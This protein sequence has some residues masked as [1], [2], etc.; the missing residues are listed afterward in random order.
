MRI[1]FQVVLSSL[2]RGR[3]LLHININTIAWLC[4][5]LLLPAASAA[6]S[7]SPVSW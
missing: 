4:S 7:S 6:Q 1:Y 5:H 2:E 3:L